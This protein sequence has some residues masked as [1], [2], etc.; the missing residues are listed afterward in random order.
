MWY[1]DDTKFKMRNWFDHLP[2]IAAELT[3]DQWKAVCIADAAFDQCVVLYSRF[4]KGTP[5]VTNELKPEL[6]KF[7][8]KKLSEIDNGRAAVE[9]LVGNDNK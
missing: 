8:R 2:V 5:E 4:Y 1:D 7:L 9:H 3:Y 6:I